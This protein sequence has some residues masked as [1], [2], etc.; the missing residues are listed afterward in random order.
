MT[1][2]QVN[3]NVLASKNEDVKILQQ[4]IARLKNLLR[5]HG[6]SDIPQTQVEQQSDL[7]SFNNIH[8][9]EEETQIHTYPA[10]IQYNSLER[11]D[12][13]SNFCVTPIQTTID[14][15][16][17]SSLEIEQ[18]STKSSHDHKKTCEKII[19][20]LD[21]VVTTVDS[22]LRT[23]KL[24]NIVP[25]TSSTDLSPGINV[26][27]VPAISTSTFNNDTITTPVELK[28]LKRNDVDTIKPTLTSKMVP[29]ES[30]RLVNENRRNSLTSLLQ[31]RKKLQGVDVQEEKLKEQIQMAKKQQQQKLQLHQWLLEKEEKTQYP[32][33]SLK[34]NME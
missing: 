27:D 28:Q 26:K 2:A 17:D 34:Y 23:M 32:Y 12:C 20:A 16:N 11:D 14:V 3:E 5:S 9:G 24:N 21:M 6:I 7:N 33:N 15:I 19:D 31:Q 30:G 1:F 29:K 22:F 18:Q 10:P 13:E 25:E 4:E 8:L